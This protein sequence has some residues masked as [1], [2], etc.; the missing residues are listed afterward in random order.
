MLTLALDAST[1]A[2]SVAVLD[3]DRVIAECDVAMRGEHAERLMPAIATA[4]ETRDMRNLRRVVCGSGPGSFTSLRIAASLAKGIAR[5]RDIPLYAVPSLLL[6]VAGA[7]ETRAPGRYLA[8]L[9]AMRGDVFAACYEVASSGDGI[10][11]VASPALARRDSVA[12]IAA[13]LRARTIGPSEA[14]VA[15]PRA[16]GVAR[17]SAWLVTREHVDLTSW[18]PD[19]G[20]L[21]EAQ[22][23]WEAAHG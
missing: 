20:R 18:E 6:M 9:D 17:L 14:I 23:R 5:G 15:H 13:S 8:V 22:V 3:G 11:E 2:G 16:R 12:E 10:L 19:Y 7:P 1:Y 4:L 21:A